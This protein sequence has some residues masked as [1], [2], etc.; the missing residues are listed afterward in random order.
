MAMISKPHMQEMINLAVMPQ[1]AEA[2]D[3]EDD[4]TGITDI[5]ARR[6]KQNRL[7]VRAFRE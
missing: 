1:L 3:K 6:K 7:N 2:M 5:V 4:W